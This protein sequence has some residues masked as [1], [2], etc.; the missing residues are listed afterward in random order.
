MRISGSY[1]AVVKLLGSPSSPSTPLVPGP[2]TSGISGAT[3]IS[4]VISNLSQVGYTAVDVTSSIPPPAQPCG[5]P[6]QA[7]TL[8]IDSGSDYVYIYDLT[9]VPAVTAAQCAVASSVYTQPYLA[10]S[11]SSLVPVSLLSTTIQGSIPAEI[12]P[13]GARPVASLKPMTPLPQLGKATTVMVRPP[14]AFNSKLV[15]APVLAQQTAIPVGNTAGA[16]VPALFSMPPPLGTNDWLPW[17]TGAGLA[18][19]ALGGLLIL[20]K[21]R[22]ATP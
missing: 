10:V 1:G 4:N 8:Q 12:V 14:T 16:V 22:S 5:A 17:L 20:K 3:F 9:G 19:V 7:W 18:V 21:S 15:S 11:A 6:S 2:S 13:L